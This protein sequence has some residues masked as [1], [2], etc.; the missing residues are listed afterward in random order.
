MMPNGLELISTISK[1]RKYTV[2]IHLFFFHLI[3]KHADM[4]ERRL[5][6]PLR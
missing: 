3:K 5:P 2:S 1:Q 6:T 4:Q